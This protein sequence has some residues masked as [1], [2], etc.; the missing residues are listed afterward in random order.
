MDIRRHSDHVSGIE[1]Q[2]GP[3][4]FV[5]TASTDTVMC[6]WRISVR[7][8]PPSLP[9]DDEELTCWDKDGALVL[10]YKHGGP[11][12]SIAWHPTLPQIAVA[13]GPEENAVIDVS[14]LPV[15]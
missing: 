10:E 8:F 14:S 13:G 9:L 12:Y 5:A 4:S 2:P 1:F 6:I 7:P 15:L 11:I 3:E